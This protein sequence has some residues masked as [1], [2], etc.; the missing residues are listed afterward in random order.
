MTLL[1]P[2]ELKI[3]GAPFPAAVAGSGD[4]RQSGAEEPSVSEIERMGPS[5][6][7]GG[8]LKSDFGL[9]GAV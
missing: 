7:A 6:W 5:Q 9:S 1:P 8:P 4:F 2:K 3:V